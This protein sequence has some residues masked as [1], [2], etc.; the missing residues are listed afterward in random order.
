MFAIAIPQL[1]GRNFAT[2]YPYIYPY[3]AP[4]LHIPFVIATFSEV[5]N[6]KSGTF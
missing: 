4:L 6:F 1:E 3:F 2:A 5:P